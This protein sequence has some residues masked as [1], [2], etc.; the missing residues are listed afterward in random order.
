MKEFSGKKV[1]ITGADGFI[2]STLLEKLV[3]AGAD[4]TALVYYNSWDHIGWLSDCD[5]SVIDEVRIV[6]GDIRDSYFIKKSVCNSNYIFHLSSL[7][8]IPYSYTAAQSY[9]DTNIHG[10]LNIAQ[11]SLELD[12]L[13]CLLHVSTSE[14]YGS[15]QKLPMDEEHPLV[16]QSPYSA[17]KIGADKIVQSF[18]LSFDLPVVIARPFNTYGPRQTS[19]AVIPTIISQVI[20]NLDLKLGN[21]NAKRDFNY[22][23]DTAK[24]MMSL[25]KSDEAIG[26]EINI[27]SG[28]VWSIGET[29]ELISEIS[30]K[31]LKIIQ[32][33]QRVRPE[34]S[35]VTELLCDNSKIIKLTDWRHETDFKSGLTKTF[36]WIE[37]NINQFPTDSYNI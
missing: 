35:E 22:V 14:V 13:D 32:E 36:K 11:A 25:A 21:L 27:G 9:I 3:K 16:G 26:E 1:Y 33:G 8:G 10:A 4:V 24:G 31:K 6:K 15:A 2:G 19:R 29:I 7:I 12:S 5:K 28:E 23:T 17:S 18:N 37:K 20:K 30:G 34:K